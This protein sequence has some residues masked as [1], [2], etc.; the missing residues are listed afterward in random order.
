MQKL[1]IKYSLTKSF[2][3]D[4]HC[5]TYQVVA[6]ALQNGFEM[7]ATKR[8]FSGIT[9]VLDVK[10]I[11]WAESKVMSLFSELAVTTADKW[12]SFIKEN[13]YG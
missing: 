9:V 7:T 4:G 11:P 1:N 2:E 5:F 13:L 10:F 6:A 3:A 8:T 12:G